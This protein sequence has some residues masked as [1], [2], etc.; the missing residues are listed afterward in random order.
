MQ[1]TSALL[2]AIRLGDQ[3]RWLMQAPRGCRFFCNRV[4][5]TCGFLFPPHLHMKNADVRN[6]LCCTSLASRCPPS[7]PSAAFPQ[8]NVGFLALTSDPPDCGLVVCFCS[9]WRHTSATARD[10]GS[11]CGGAPD[12]QASRRRCHPQKLNIDFS[13]L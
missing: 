3:R 1:L 2:H 12:K 13:E 5:A 6:Q 10:T 11:R 7:S 8:T 4:L 9:Q